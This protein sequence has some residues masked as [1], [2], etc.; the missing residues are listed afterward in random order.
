M[1]PKNVEPGS[2]EDSMKAL[3]SIVRGLEQGTLPLED[4]LEQYTQATKHLKYCYEQ[5]NQAEKS[6]QLLRGM[7]ADGEADL[8]ALEDGADSLV[9]K[10]AARSKRRSAR[11]DLG[12]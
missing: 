4:S 7:N 12:E 3:E 5:L 10:Q 1:K 11:T 6:V 2:F 9:E 8:V